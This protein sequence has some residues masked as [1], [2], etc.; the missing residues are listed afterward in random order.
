[1]THHTSFDTL[2]TTIGYTFRNKELLRTAMTHSSVSV[3]SGGGSETNYERL[4]F[5]GDRVLGL[6]V[7]DLL[8]RRYPQEKEGDLA[9]RHAAL[10]QGKT[11]AKVARKLDLGEVLILSD[12]ERAAG[13]AENE[14]MLADGVESLLGALY[15]DCDLTECARLISALWDDLLD[16][17][18]A[19][20]QDPKTALQEWAQGRGLPLPSYE[21]VDR[22]G[23]DHAPEFTI[24]VQVQGFSPV[25]GHGTSRR[26]AEKNAAE[27]FLRTLS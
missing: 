24:S 17:M 12:S 13:G 1:M 20:P 15:L 3:Q 16:V 11:L 9:K 2:Q 5:L 10:V 25:D 14:H 21:M 7:A 23:P 8:Y 26:A 18:T 27:K 6:V 4:E 22:T 19:P